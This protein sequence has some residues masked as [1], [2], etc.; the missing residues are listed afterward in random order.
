MYVRRE[1]ILYSS[2]HNALLY[3]IFL[4]YPTEKYPAYADW[5]SDCLFKKCKQIHML[6]TLKDRTAKIS[7]TRQLYN[8][9]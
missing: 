6:N 5:V 4:Y 3:V 2:T 1:R 9:Y 8:G 7:Y